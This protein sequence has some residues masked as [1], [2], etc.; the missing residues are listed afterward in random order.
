PLHLE[1]RLLG[2]L[3]MRAR[4]AFSRDKPFDLATTA[5]IATAIA[6]RH[7]RLVEEAREHAEREMARYEAFVSQ[8]SDGVAVLDVGHGGVLLT[9][10]GAAILGVH[11]DVR[12]KPFFELA[13]PTNAG[14]QLLLREISRGSRVVS[15]DLEVELPGGRKVLAFSAGPLK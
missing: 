2:M 14:S 1:G 8:L 7:A 11:D 5:S 15:A 4:A 13:R 6:V 9:P 3:M 10:A 12:G